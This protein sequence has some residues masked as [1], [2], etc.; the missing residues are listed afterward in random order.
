M[1]M[2][3]ISSTLLPSA[4]STPSPTPSLAHLLVTAD[5]NP[6]ILSSP[7]LSLITPA[8]SSVPSISSSFESLHSVMEDQPKPECTCLSL[9]TLISLS[10][11]F[12]P[13]LAPLS[14]DD[15]S[16]LILPP[17]PQSASLAPL[18]KSLPLKPTL[19]TL[20]PS[21]ILILK[22]DL[23]LCALSPPPD[24]SPAFLPS[25]ST[26]EILFWSSSVLSMLDSLSVLLQHDQSLSLLEILSQ[27]YRPLKL[28]VEPTPVPVL[29]GSDVLLG[30]P[31]CPPSPLDDI[32]LPLLSTPLEVSVI[33]PIPSHSL[34][35]Q[36]SL[37]V[38][39][40]GPV[41]SP[42]E[43]TPFPAS[44]TIP[45]TLQQVLT[46]APQWLLYLVPHW[47][48]LR[49]QEP[50]LS[51][52]V[53]SMH[54]PPFSHISIL[55]PQWLLYLVPQLFRLQ[56]LPM[57]HEVSLTPFVPCLPH[58]SPPLLLS[59]L[60]SSFTHFNFTLTLVTTASLFSIL[61]N[62]SKTIFTHVHKVQS[63]N[64]DIGSSQTGNPKT[65]DALAQWLWLGQTRP[66][67][68]AS[69]LTWEA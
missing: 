48:L 45:S 35:L 55:T 16:K 46:L 5:N 7:T 31:E 54:A 14:T 26:F 59:S 9:I 43:V 39:S 18:L 42:L 65:Y 47:Q 28:Q 27:S 30:S 4:S 15:A 33:A 32:I 50:S 64:E 58:A 17:T 51:S 3:L 68:H 13:S 37:G 41:S 56:E 66:M 19:L 12:I 69:C 38:T 36:Q 40:N 20:P 60:S 8:P 62:I 21:E 34:P 44:T 52:D 2:F 1:P 22:L 57:A 23:P 53:S 24:H 29:A 63:K 11:P 67:P 25:P 49:S 6:E 10:L 61:L